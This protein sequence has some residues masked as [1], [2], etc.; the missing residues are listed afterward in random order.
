MLASNS[1]VGTLTV[2]STFDNTLISERSL[3]GSQSP[4]GS[5]GITVVELAVL[6]GT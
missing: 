5:L 3:V 6:Y 2:G 4:L 1:G